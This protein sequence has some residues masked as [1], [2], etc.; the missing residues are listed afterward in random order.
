[1]VVGKEVEEELS[2][3]PIH[4]HRHHSLEKNALSGTMVIRQ[5]NHMRSNRFALCHNYHIAVQ[6]SE[7]SNGIEKVDMQVLEGWT[8]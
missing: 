8:V 6:T 3:M 2:N 1:M 4:L 7:L 5:Q